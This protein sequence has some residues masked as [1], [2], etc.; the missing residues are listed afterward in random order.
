MTEPT[1]NAGHTLDLVI[2]RSET[3]ISELRVG[4]MISDPALI[5][6]TLPVKRDRLNASDVFAERVVQA[7][8]QDFLESNRLMP[9]TVRVPEIP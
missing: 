7:S 9:K 6:F 4:D 2:T 3:V 8:L 5:R 1:H